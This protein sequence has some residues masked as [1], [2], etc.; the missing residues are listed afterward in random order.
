MLHKLLEVTFEGFLDRVPVWTL[1]QMAIVF[2]VA[3]FLLNLGTVHLKRL[4]SLVQVVLDT[5]SI[6]PI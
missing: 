1:E 6:P 2:F 3:P 5:Y 4:Q